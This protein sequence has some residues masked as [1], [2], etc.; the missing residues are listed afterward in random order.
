V[1]AKRAVIWSGVSSKIQAHDDKYSLEQQIEDG[2]TLAQRNGWQ[3][4]A[5]LVVPGITRSSIDLGDAIDALD[6]ALASDRSGLYA[7]KLR[8]LQAGGDNAY[9]RFLELIAERAFDVLIC[10]SRD[11][12]GRTDSLIAGVEERVRRIDGMVYSMSMPPTGS[13]TGDL[14]VSAFERAGA[15]EYVMRLAANRRKGIDQRV[16][17]GY[18]L[19][20]RLPYGYRADWQTV[21]NRRVRVALPVEEEIEAYRWMIDAFLAGR[22]YDAIRAHMQAVSPA[23]TWANSVITRLLR[24]TFHLG[25]IIHDRKR[26]PE[27][28]E[29]I[30]LVR[31]GAIMDQPDWGRLVEWLHHEVERPKTGQ[32]RDQRAPRTLVVGVGLHQPAVDLRT[33][34]AVQDILDYR[35]QR[36]RRPSIHGIWTRVLFCGVCGRVMSPWLR[37]GRAPSYRCPARYLGG[38]CDNPGLVEHKVTALIVQHLRTLMLEHATNDTERQQPG[39]VDRVAFYERELA[40]LAEQRKRIIALYTSGRIEL[41]ELDDLRTANDDQTAATRAELN[42]LDRAGYQRQQVTER[43]AVLREV[44]PHMEVY[45]A[46]MPAQTANR[47]MREIF[48]RIEITHGAVSAIVV[49]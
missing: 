26:Q 5:R 49:L 9:R 19:T 25:L 46:A 36:R 8:S 4:V 22:T 32:R 38:D 7:G 29:H 41:E 11:R 6:E 23:L 30:Q 40:S 12:L 35:S 43:L 21:A 10:H 28:R 34:L 44:L 20:G 31:S 17:S 14:Y 39:E 15:Q 3:V 16:R 2:E 18:I 48:Q 27:D 1:Q 45:L 13:R 24:S 47:L 37:P 42:L 33:W